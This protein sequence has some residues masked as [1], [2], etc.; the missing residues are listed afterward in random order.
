MKVKNKTKEPTVD[1]Q[2][3]KQGELFRFQSNPSRTTVAIAVGPPNQLGKP[4]TGYVFLDQG[5]YFDLAPT[6]RTDIIKIKTLNVLEVADRN[7]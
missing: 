6:T 1:I 4:V 7:D 3:L 2:T 5:G